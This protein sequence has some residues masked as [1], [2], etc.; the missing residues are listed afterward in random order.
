MGKALLV[1]QT[2]LVIDELLH[3][4]IILVIDEV[5]RTHNLGK[6]TLHYRKSLRNEPYDTIKL[7]NKV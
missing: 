3:I 1:V 7:N 6:A 4:N 2:C 5:L